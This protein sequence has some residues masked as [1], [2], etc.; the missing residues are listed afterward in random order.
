MKIRA[1][2]FEDDNTLRYVVKCALDARGYEVMVFE[3]PAECALLKNHDC[4]CESNEVCA[5]IMVSDVDMPEVSGLEFAKTQTRKGCKIVSIG[6][7]SGRWSEPQLKEARELGCKTF[8]KPLDIGELN[9]WL[10]ECELRIP[11]DRM[12]SDWYL[13]RGE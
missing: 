1:L 7:M 3:N 9:H 13:K 10:D 8:E 4:R 2:V 5:D 11:K 6:L 12:L